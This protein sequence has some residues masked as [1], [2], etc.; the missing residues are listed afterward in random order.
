MRGVNVI[1]Y[2]D[3]P[4]GLGA[5]ARLIVQALQAA[6][7]PHATVRVTEGVRPPWRAPPS[8]PYDA[9]LVCVNA[10]ML[11]RVVQS[12]GHEAFDARATIGFW[13]WEVDR[14]PPHLAWAA[15][16]LDEVWV[17]SDHVRH[18]VAPLVRRPVHVV[19]IPVPVGDADAS[20]GAPGHKGRFSFL[21]AFNYASVFERK[22]PLGAIEAFARAFAP[23]EAA[24][25]IKTAGGALFPDEVARLTRAAA[26]HPDVVVIDGSLAADEYRALTESA[27][28]YVSLHRAEG[29]GLTIAEAMALGKPAIATAYSGNLEFMSPDNSYLVP[30]TLTP[31]SEGTPYP[32]DAQWADPDLDVA[33]SQLRAVYDDREEA[34][35]RGQEGRRT[36]ATT[37]SFSV[38]GQ[39]IAD[40]LEAVQRAMP[41]GAADLAAAL[42]LRGPDLISNRSWLHLMRRLAQPLFRPYVEHDVEIT[43]LILD[44]V[45]EERNE[46]AKRVGE[47]E[48]RLDALDRLGSADE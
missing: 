29:F 40:R 12:L 4:T 5:V 20:N 46:L 38:A 47:L 2:H 10:D 36:L 19:P 3:A 13:W 39:F 8:L 30:Y 7:V 17:G 32:A 26:E 24:L 41:S 18:A 43:Q 33:A 44:A 37:R 1:G 31:V 28:A 11:P 45:T 25:V 16:L 42:A 48:A 21:F 14:F 35:R 27:N 6:S 15:Q 9:N 34:T 22:N 23:G